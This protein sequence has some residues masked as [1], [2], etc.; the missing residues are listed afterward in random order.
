MKKESELTLPMFAV[1][2]LRALDFEMGKAIENQRILDIINKRIIELEKFIKDNN[3]IYSE[4]W[5]KITKDRI[6]ELQKILLI[7][8]E[9]QGETK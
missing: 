7:I 5:I 4:V 6:D 3:S 1:D 8:K 2:K 9:E